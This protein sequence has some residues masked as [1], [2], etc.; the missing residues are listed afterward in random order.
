M[1]QSFK[2][3]R[4]SSGF[5]VKSF[6][7]NILGFPC[8]IFVFCQIIYG[9]LCWSIQIA[10]VFL[11]FL[12][13]VFFVKYPRFS[14]SMIFLLNILRFPCQ[15]SFCW[16]IQAAKVFHGFHCQMFSAFLVKSPL[17][18]ILGFPCQILFSVKYSTIS[19][20]IFLL[21][22]NSNCKGF[23]LGLEWKVSQGYSKNI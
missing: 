7:S 14:L 13:Q 6:L 21:L 17:S 19:L 12:C 9:F 2:E 1:D 16:S 4:F 8:H 15:F 11:G 5:L 22:V 23:V 10:K 3:T 20:P 18:N